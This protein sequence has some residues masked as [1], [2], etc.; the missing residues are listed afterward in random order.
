MIM[1]DI[2]ELSTE[3]R[4]MRTMKLDEMTPYQII[5]IMNEEEG[6]KIIQGKLKHN[7]KRFPIPGAFPQHVFGDLI[8]LIC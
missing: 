7:K 5:S 1:E 6:I 4:N 8:P 2:S 3:K